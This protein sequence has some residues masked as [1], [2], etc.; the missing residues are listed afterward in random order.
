MDLNLIAA[1]YLTKFQINT[2]VIWN[3]GNLEILLKKHFF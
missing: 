3:L 2:F 1:Q